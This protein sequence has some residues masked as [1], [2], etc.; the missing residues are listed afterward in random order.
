MTRYHFEANLP[1][2]F[3]QKAARRAKSWFSLVQLFINITMYFLWEAGNLF[4]FKKKN[5]PN[6]IK[7]EIRHFCQKLILK[8]KFTTGV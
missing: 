8:K 6:A 4:N 3:R 1:H 2:Y 7:R 5:T